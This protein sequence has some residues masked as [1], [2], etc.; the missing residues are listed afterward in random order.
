VALVI[1]DLSALAPRHPSELPEQ[2]DDIVL[3][4]VYRPL[5]IT[6]KRYGTIFKCEYPLMGT[7]DS[8]ATYRHYRAIRSA[9]LRVTTMTIVGRLAPTPRITPLLPSTQPQTFGIPPTIPS[10]TW[11]VDDLALPDADP[12]L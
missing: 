12:P 4:P 3:D 2:Y 6:G 9:A 1:D 8:A 11:A 7:C 5:V 10:F